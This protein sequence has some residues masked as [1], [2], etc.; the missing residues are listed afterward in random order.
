V[1]RGDDLT[2]RQAVLFD[3]M[4]NLVDAAYYN[5]TTVS[6]KTLMQVTIRI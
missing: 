5:Q 2:S 6:T 3:E 1:Q 4:G